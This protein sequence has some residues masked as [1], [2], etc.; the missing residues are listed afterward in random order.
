[1]L[2]GFLHRNGVRAVDRFNLPAKQFLDIGSQ[3]EL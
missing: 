3:V 2:F 1:M